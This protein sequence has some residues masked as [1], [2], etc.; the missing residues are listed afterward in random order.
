MI[1]SVI[2]YGRSFVIGAMDERI[3]GLMLAHWRTPSVDVAVDHDQALRDAVGYL[4]RAQE[5]G[6]DDGLRSYHLIKGWGSSYPETTG[7]AIPTLLA[8]GAHLNW[9]EPKE[10]AKRAAEWLLS[11]QRPDGGWQG[12]R[13]GEERPSIVFNTAQV[14][15][16]MLAMHAHTG[17]AKYVESAL[18][19]GRWIASVQDGDG[20]W[21]ASNFLGVARVYDTYVDAPLLHLAH[22]TG[23]KALGQAALRNL[24][25][26][27]S[28]R[29]PNGWF[30]NADNTTEHNAR[31]ITHTVAYT[32]DGLVECSMHTGDTRYREAALNAALELAELFL[33]RGLLSGRYDR[34]WRG[35]E[36]L[37]TTG[38]AQLAIIWSRLENEQ[39]MRE[40]RDRMIVLLTDIQARSSVGPVVVK[41]AMPGSFPLWGRYEKFAFPNWGTKY[42]A[43]AL[44]CAQG[45]LPAF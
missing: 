28:Q 9:N 39:H 35:S 7:Y 21:R 26:V 19:A 30:A 31:P 38:C 33:E 23:D 8:A 4:L 43:D 40:A 18:R 14:I 42:L 10:A 5:Q 15:R 16:G 41:G 20:A 24:E 17:E 45:Q 27:L 13:V 11:V 36:H 37:I 1:R 3:R 2:D 29:H 32:L 25:W 22:V 34:Q 44:L 6:Q 12:G